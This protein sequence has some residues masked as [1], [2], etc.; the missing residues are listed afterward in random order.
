MSRHEIITTASG[1]RA[2]PL[3]FFEFPTE[4]GSFTGTL[5][6]RAWHT[7]KPCLVCYFITDD[8]VC[9]KLFAWFNNDYSPRKSGISFADDV[10]NGSRWKCEFEISPNGSA[11]WLTA[12][13]VPH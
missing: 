6:Y 3:H 10:V 8:E 12:E 1:R 7:K 2:A 13:E 9:Y 4:A 11:T 5:E